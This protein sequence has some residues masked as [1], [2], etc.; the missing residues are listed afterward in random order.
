MKLECGEVPSLRCRHCRDGGGWR[1]SRM[2]GEMKSKDSTIRG[3]GVLGESNSDSVSTA[4]LSG[5]Q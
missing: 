3:R 4:A 2:T 5:D 1:P